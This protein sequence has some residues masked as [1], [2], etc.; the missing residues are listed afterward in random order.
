M[1]KINTKKYRD[2]FRKA[3]GIEDDIVSTI[4]HVFGSPP[5]RIID[6]HQKL[7]EMGNSTI[8]LWDITKPNIHKYRADLVLDLG[9]YTSRNSNFYL[10]SSK[11][12]YH[13]ENF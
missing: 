2:L 8:L 11:D 10:Y 13:K 1:K 9:L 12:F 6:S 7:M 3:T 5:L 4:D